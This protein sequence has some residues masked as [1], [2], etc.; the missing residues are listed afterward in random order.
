MLKKILLGLF[1]LVLAVPAFAGWG[2]FQTY[3]VI[4]AGN[5]NTFRAGGANA[6]GAA[7]V[8]GYHYGFFNTN[9]T[10]ILNGGEVK[11]FKNGGGNVCGGEIFYAVYKSCEGSGTFTSVSIP[12]NGELGGG[13]QRWQNTTAN[14]NLLSG[15]S[16]GDYVLEVYWRITGDDANGCN[17]DQFDSNSGAN[18]KAFFTVGDDGFS[19]NN[20]SADVTWSGNTT[21]FAVVDASSLTGDGSNVNIGSATANNPSVLLSNASTGEAAITT[22]STQAYGVWEFSIA[23][24]LNWDLSDANNFAVILT[25][26]TNDDTKLKI[27]AAMDFNG[28]Y[29]KWKSDVA[30]D[31]LVLVRRTGLTEAEI[32]D[33]NYPLTANAY[34][35]YTIKVVRSTDGEFDVYADAGFDN[36]DAVT[37]RGS[38]RDN[39]ITTSSYFAVSTNITNP[40]AA[41]RLYFDNLLMLPATEVSFTTATGTVEETSSDFTYT[42][43]LGI[44][45]EDDRCPAS[46]DV[47][48]ISGDATRI[49]NYAT[50]TITWAAN[51]ATDK[52]VTI[53]ISGNDLCQIEETLVFELQNFTGG[54]NT[55]A[56]GNPRFTLTLEDDESGTDENVAVDFEDNDLSAWDLGGD[57][58]TVN[59]IA[60]I[61]G[62]YDLKHDGSVATSDYASLN[63]DNLELRGAETRWRF[64]LKHGAFNTSANNWI[65]AVLAGSEAD[66][67]SAS[68]DGY[69][70]GVNFGTTTDN[71]RL[72]RIDNGVYTDLI[73]SSLVLDTNNEIYGIEVIRSEDGTWS[74][75]YQTGGGWDALTDAGS[76]AV[77]GN[78][79]LANYFSF[80]INVTL[81]NA[82]KPRIDDIQVR[83]YGC[84][85]EWYSVASGD[86]D[87]AIWSQDPLSAQGETFVPGKFKR[88]NVQAAHTVDLTQDM[89]ASDFSV[90]G[91]LIG[92]G[93]ELKLFGNL[94]NDGTFTAENSTVT[95][96]GS[97]AQVIVG[98]SISTFNNLKIDNTGSG[99][100]LLSD[101]NIEGVL[102]PEEGTLDLGTSDLT[103]I[104]DATG[105]GGIGPFRNG[106]SIVGDITMQRYI[107]SGQQDWVNLGAPLTGLTIDDWNDDFPTTGFPGSDF[108]VYPF[109]NIQ[110]YD[111]SMSGDLNNGWEETGN[112]TDALE[113]DRG[114]MV[115]MNG[116]ALNVD[117]KGSLQQG[118]IT[119]PLN[120]TSADGLAIDGWNLVVNKYPSE[121]DW[122]AMVANSTGVSTYYIYDAETDS[123]LSYNGNTGLGTAPRYIAMG[124]SF[125][126]KADAPGAVL[127]WDEN[128]KS[129]SG[130]VFE[131]SFANV[132]HL[133]LSLSGSGLNDVVVLG[134]I[135]GATSNYENG[136]DALKLGSMNPNQPSLSLTSEDGYAL[137][138]N[139]AGGVNGNFSVPVHIAANGAGTYTFSIEDL[140]DLPSSACISIENIESGEIAV[141]EEG[142]SW[143]VDVAENSAENYF[144]I[145]FE[146]PITLEA[147]EVSCYGENNGSV[148]VSGVAGGTL[149][150]YDEMDQLIAVEENFNGSSSIENLPFGNYTAELVNSEATCSSRSETIYIDTPN[151]EVLNSWSQIAS[152]NEDLSGYINLTSEGGEMSFEVLNEANEVVQSGSFTGSYIIDELNAENY[153]V[154][155]QSAC[156]SWEINSDLSDPNNI[157]LQTQDQVDANIVNNFALISLNA[158]TTADANIEWYYN[159]TLVGSGEVLDYI[160]TQDGE[161]VFEVFAYND[162]C[163]ANSSVTVNASTSVGLEELSEEMSAY[164][165]GQALQVEMNG[166]SGVM[167]MSVYN[168]VGQ[169]VYDTQITANNGKQSFNLN[170]IARGIHHARFTNEQGFDFSVK[171][172]K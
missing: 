44:I 170:G 134:F 50:Q 29:L 28:Y 125:W 105:D 95:F 106:A 51:D 109:N 36:V 37:L 142:L 43:D 151:E 8:N 1:A 17:L 72:V 118:S 146:A 38:V 58:N 57:W 124:Q 171:F 87:D 103:L 169:L 5:G 31:K 16:D 104:S 98:S 61:S 62:S 158:S 55:Q 145:H 102:S 12:Y 41:R 107:G 90:S 46:A 147:T 4:D 92:S 94:A 9:D 30:G 25:S 114:Y 39:N 82:G 148:A 27:G 129:S 52:T 100:T 21:D 137:Q 108:D 80:A 7:V 85:E 154:L 42:F 79:V 67:F 164:Y 13:D 117:V 110:K 33:L 60:T 130:V 40:S 128:A 165:D 166:L 56:A 157:G 135:D 156:N 49:D 120:F 10:F 24:G 144:L 140:V 88:V 69:A 122:D 45:G 167:N 2:I 64:N 20:L 99:V 162:Q 18:F 53:T 131:R 78:H 68:L 73:S 168:S 32:L 121:I 152:C 113:T 96:K 112:I 74:F 161:Y 48:L 71:F 91:T 149:S 132:P 150:W 123:Y 143:T 26:D 83:Q 84:Q 81:G 47:V 70:V 59:S 97:G 54:I 159:G 86:S 133:A 76:T 3:A 14:V 65:M 111:E 11:T 160:F 63:L 119:Q 172:M 153:T 101:V 139:A 35:G 126:A 19:D 127:Q 141:L 77:D 136:T 93:A 15:L 138:Q 22:P 163:S 115:F 155:V 116:G 34:G 75:G 6:D 66:A 89:I 23:S